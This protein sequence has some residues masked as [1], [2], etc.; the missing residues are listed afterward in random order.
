MKV[1]VGHSD[2]SKLSSV[3]YLSVKEFI[4]HP[5]WNS[6]TKSY[7]AD[8]AIV[9]LENNLVFSNKVQ[10]S[11]LPKDNS[12]ALVTDGYIVSHEFFLSKATDL[13]SFSDRLGKIRRQ[14]QA[15]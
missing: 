5:D 7:D 10:P 15:S 13:F 4:V 1:S 3:D 11:C 6:M 14:N 9:V 2:L 12:I 8:I